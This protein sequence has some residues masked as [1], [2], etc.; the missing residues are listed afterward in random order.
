MSWIRPHV[1]I[2]VVFHNMGREAPRTLATLTTAYQKGVESDAYEVIIVDNGS[3]IPMN[4]QMIEIF[5]EN[6]QFI[7]MDAG[8]SPSACINYAAQQARGD[9]LM[10]CIDGARM[11]SPGIV[12][13]TLQAAQCFSSSVIATIALHLGPKVQNEAMLEGYNQDAEDQLLNSID[14]FSNGYQLFSI[15]CLAGSSNRGLLSSPN[16][17]NCLTVHRDVFHELGG[18]DEKFTSAGGGLVNLDFYKRAC[19]LTGQVILLLGEGTFH[20]FHGGVATNVPPHLH[21]WKAYANEYQ[22]I[23]GES[24]SPPRMTPILLGSLDPNTF[25]FLAQSVESLKR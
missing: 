24:Y 12:K 4:T 14:W 8:P 2:I 5:G 7:R 6:F 9:F 13:L 18:F 19:E 21:P 20:Q 25:R 17:S 23:R 22:S 10:I 11:L 16:E 3:D 15:S 1:S